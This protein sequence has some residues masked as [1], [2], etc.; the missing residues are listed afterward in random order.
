MTRVLGLCLFFALGAFSA[1]SLALTPG[2]YRCVSFNAGG[3]GGRCPS[4]TPIEIRADG[5]YTE[6]STTGR[7]AVKDGQV[8]FSESRIRGPGQLIDDSAIRFQYVYNGLAYTV[9]YQCFDCGG[10]AAPANRATGAAPM[11]VGVS[12]LI[13][14]AERANGAT[15][16]VIVPRES[17]SQFRHRSAFPAGAVS[18]LVID[19]SP[20]VLSLGTSRNNRLAV[21]R[22]Y[23][24]FLVSPAETVPVAAFHLPA[25]Q[26]D[27]QG[28]LRGALYRSGLPPVSSSSATM[29][30]DYPPPPATATGTYPGPDTS[31]PS[32]PSSGFAPGSPA[33]GNPGAVPAVK[34]NPNTPKYSQ[35]GCVE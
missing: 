32:G 12:L 30:G 10:P 16:F 29:P 23:V 31:Y 13:E 8:V 20:Y 18:G 21:G 6:S 1:S 14:F 33:W 7:Y 34:C 25:V 26:S 24:V 28:R 19:I 9:T 3:A 4:T 35:P 22:P 2:A 15:G 17:A 27:Y 5:T 11:M